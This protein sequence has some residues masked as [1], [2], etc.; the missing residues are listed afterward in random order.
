MKSITREARGVSWGSALLVFGLVM[1]IQ[2]I[3]GV[4]V[5][6]E[7][8]FIAAFLSIATYGGVSVAMLFFL[9]ARYEPEIEGEAEE[10]EERITSAILPHHPALAVR[11]PE[12]A[13]N[14]NS[15]LQG[16]NRLFVGTSLYA[17]NPD[18]THE[19]LRRI[20]ECK[21]EGKL[22]NVS[23][24]QLHEIGFS[25]HTG[26]AQAVLAD[27]EQAG[28]VISA[29]ERQPMMWTTLGDR[30]FLPPPPTSMNNRSVSG[31]GGIPVVN[32]ATTT[33]HHDQR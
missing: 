8:L 32:H 18:V 7:S 6:S 16:T 22:E 29:G 1:A 11:V 2:M 17:L 30:V 28:L 21:Y 19:D 23:L 24:R 26:K 3:G 5:N 4:G 20:A 27:L 13:Q 25:R 12:W 15:A 14:I 33:H 31:G 10:Q 9:R